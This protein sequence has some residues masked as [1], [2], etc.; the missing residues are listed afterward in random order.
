[1]Y[2][3]GNAALATKV[4]LWDD[5][6]DILRDRNQ[7]GPEL[8]L[9]CSRH[10]EKYL[11]VKNPEDFQQI[12]PEGGCMEKCG[13]DLECGHGCELS[14]HPLRRHKVILCRKRCERSHPECGHRC[15]K[16]CY[17][18]CGKCKIGVKDV[19]LPCG[20]RLPIAECWLSRNLDD[21]EA[22][23]RAMIVRRLEK[24][25]HE[26]EMMCSDRPEEFQCTKQCGGVSTCQLHQ[27]CANPCS[28]CTGLGSL[29]DGRR[30]HAPC[31]QSCEKPFTTCSHGC[32]RVCH[33]SE[34]PDCGSCDELCEIRCVHSQC[35][36]KCGRNCIPCTEPCNWKCIHKGKCELPCGAPCDRLPCDERCSQLLD[37]GHRCPSMCGEI[38]PPSEFCQI[39][40]PPS[41]RETTVGSIEF[42]K[43]NLDKD[44]IVVLPCQHFYT[45]SH[46]DERLEIKK[47]YICDEDGGFVRSVWSDV[48]P[49]QQRQCPQCR[50]WISKIHRYGRIFK[51]AVLDNI[52][53]SIISCFREQYVV[54]AQN[55]NVFEIEIRSTSK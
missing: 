33:S 25:G 26:V 46:L 24:C 7:I 3:I 52:L 17:E 38:C 36:E 1:M 20:H 4:E 42:A 41:R 43:V 2:I 18:P 35:S 8:R 15:P 53:R 19:P 49:F 40:G 9:C 29:P 45:R 37:C 48:L 5:V 50:M 34:D 14:C 51:R 12:A 13:Q 32:R 22:K 54:V 30:R 55:M 6:V 47:A 39:C 27:I 16:L 28:T 23:C 21:P 44:P 10:E 11:A 31:S